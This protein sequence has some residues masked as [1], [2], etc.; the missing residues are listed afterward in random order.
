[1]WVGISAVGVFETDD[2]GKT[3]EARNK[4][5]RADYLPD[6]Y[7]EIGVCVHKVGLHPDRPEVLYQQNHS[8]VYRSDDGGRS[9]TDISNG[10]PSR[11]GFPLVV[12]P[13]DPRTIWTVPL[14][15]DDR[16]RFMPDGQAAVWR[17][18]DAGATWE[19][20]RNGLPPA[21]AYVGVLREALAIDRGDPVGHLHGH[22]H[23]PALRQPRR[24]RQLAPPR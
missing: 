12:H 20:Q 7:P 16:G 11:F 9:W 6:P 19:A 15:G 5:V 14:S 4:G 21:H 2:A 24:R 17:S 22:E 1:M 3:W 13:H 8:G 10:L 23:G 18:R